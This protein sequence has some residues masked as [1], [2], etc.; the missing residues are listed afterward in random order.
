MASI[1]PLKCENTGYY[2]DN[3]GCPQCTC[4]DVKPCECGPFPTEQKPIL[5]PDGKTEVKLIN[6]CRASD[7]NVCSFI[8]TECP[9]GF[10]VTVP[11]GATLT[12]ADLA[13]IKAELG[14]T[15]IV[16]TKSE[17]PTA[18]GGTKYTLWIAQTQLPEGTK[19]ADVNTKIDT[20]VKSTNPGSASFIV[21][22][23]STP[24]QSF[25]IN[26]VPL[27]GLFLAVLFF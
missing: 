19:V 12:E 2:T 4:N 1:C 26:L 15:V 27:F 11:K 14:V 21:S 17:T 22:D 13:K 8:R 10:D 3:D 7:A 24:T 9:F 23:G 20:S 6:I 5:C 16:V 18:D 25:A